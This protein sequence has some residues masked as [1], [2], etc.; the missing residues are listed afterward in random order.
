MA[1]QRIFIFV[2]LFSPKTTENTSFSYIRHLLHVYGSLNR[3]KINMFL[4][5][6]YFVFSLT[7][8]SIGMGIIKQI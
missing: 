8:D 7:Q 5:S 1:H 4:L 2:L 6:V 3:M